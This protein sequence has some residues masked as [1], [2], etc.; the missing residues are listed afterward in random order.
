VRR[1]EVL[2]FVDDDV[3]VAVVQ[4]AHA[5][6]VVTVDEVLAAEPILVVAAGLDLRG[7]FDLVA[8]G[9]FGGLA[10]GLDAEL[11]EAGGSII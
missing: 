5:G 2:G 10:P 1:A 6:A 4:V 7:A 8:G 9:A 11:V 3:A